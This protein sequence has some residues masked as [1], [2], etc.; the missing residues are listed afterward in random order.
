M[1][2]FP[3]FAIS[4]SRLSAI[5]MFTCSCP[6]SGQSCDILNLADIANS[7]CRRVLH[8]ERSSFPLF[9]VGIR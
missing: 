6:D 4:A 7:I 1:F 2:D 8:L 5:S 3:F 9:S